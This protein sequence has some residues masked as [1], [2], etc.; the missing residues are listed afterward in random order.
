MSCI[1]FIH[2]IILQMQGSDSDSDEVPEISGQL[3]HKSGLLRIWRTRYYWLVGQVL[4]I[5]KSDSFES[6]YRTIEITEDTEI[7]LSTNKA[8]FTIANSAVGKYVLSGP[9]PEVFA[10]VFALR[11]CKRMDSKYSIDQFRLV[12]VLGKGFYGKVML[13]EKLDTGELFALKTIRKKKLL[14]LRQQSVVLTERNLLYSL[15]RHPFVVKL[16]FAFQTKVKFYLG[17]EYAAG[18]EILHYL[19]S[20]SLFPIDD[21][22]LY[23]AEIV[24]ALDHIHKNHIIYRDL[25]AENVLLSKDGHVKLTDFG[26][27]KEVQ[28]GSGART[29]CGTAEYLAPEIIEGKEYGFKVDWWALGVLFYQMLFG[30]VPF[31]DE[32]QA[33]LF[34]KILHDEP[35]FPKFGHKNGIDLIKK[36]LVKNPDERMDIDGIKNHPFFHGLNWDKVLRCEVKPRHF[37]GVENEMSPK[38]FCSTFLNETPIDSEECSKVTNDS[39]NV[40]GFSFGLAELNMA[41]C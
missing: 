9:L 17:L 4:Y 23:I 21:I 31:Y 35:V 19:Q 5:S 27:A 18:G 13:V 40:S 16:C 38:H 11:T 32:S 6:Y 29:F 22:R 1:Q 41:D 28:G 12:N 26:L 33:V 34:D 37:E 8:R 2:D 24:L 10:W 36:L 15:E 7:K 39:F 20:L 3:K 30:D 14:Q 25:K